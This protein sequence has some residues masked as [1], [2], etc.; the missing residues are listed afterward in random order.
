MLNI[1]RYILHYNIFAINEKNNHSLIV[2]K[3][4][5]IMTKF[6]FVSNIVILVALVLM[7][8]MHPKCDD[9][10]TCNASASTSASCE[11]IAV[12][13]VN[14]D[15]ILINYTK[16]QDLNEELMSQE[17][18]ARTSLTA[19]A[20][21]L[22]TEMQ[23]FQRKVENN[24]FL[25][26]ERAQAKQQELILKQQTLEQTQQK[27]SNELA[28]KQQDVNETVL[29]SINSFI[30]EYNVEAGYEIIF[31]QNGGIGTI[32]YANETYNI[33][34]EVLAQLNEQYKK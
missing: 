26:R 7:W 13:Y 24:G 11:K 30:A 28:L 27:K 2:I 17:E 5:S 18:E 22:E 1:V 6:N 29:E 16:A 14:I 20:R 8:V 23:E 19:Q 34:A 31:T 10:D 4:K 25:T 21:A 3:H 32:L 12:A 33:T 9:T 15:S